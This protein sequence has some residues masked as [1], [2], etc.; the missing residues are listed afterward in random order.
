[1]LLGIAGTVVIGWL[2]W[3]AALWFVAEW[4]WVWILGTVFLM[5]CLAY[6]AVVAWREQQPFAP[7]E[8]REA[9]LSGVLVSMLVVAPVVVLATGWGTAC[10][11][12]LLGLAIGAAPGFVWAGLELPRL[13][14]PRRTSGVS[15]EAET[16][17]HVNAP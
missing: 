9:W 6:G 5:P 11:A 4:R 12:L 7:S 10:V 14:P 3:L 8:R 17:T 1:M 2:V 16:A 15:V 13:L